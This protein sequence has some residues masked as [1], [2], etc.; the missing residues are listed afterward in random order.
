ME[1]N[2]KPIDEKKWK[3]L[4][5]SSNFIVILIS[6]MISPVISDY[7]FASSR[8]AEFFTLVICMLVL[9]FFRKSILDYIAIS[10]SLRKHFEVKEQQNS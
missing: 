7:Y 1:R 3:R 2:E 10:P 6:C 4:D 8:L 9:D 5:Q